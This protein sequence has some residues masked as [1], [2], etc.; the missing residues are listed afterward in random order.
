MACA[1][2]E[3]Q[4]CGGGTEIRG[5]FSNH[6]HDLLPHAIR[7]AGA[8]GRLTLAVCG[9]CGH[10]VRTP[11]RAQT[12][13]LELQQDVFGRRMSGAEI[14][15]LRRRVGWP[16]LRALVARETCRIVEGGG[17]ALDIGCGDGR[18]LATL[19]SD[20]EKY[21]IELSAESAEVARAVSGAEVFNGD[22]GDFAAP[23]ASFNLITAFS[24]ME[25]LTQPEGLLARAHELLEPGGVLV[26]ATPDR[27]SV[28]ARRL[29]E[30]WQIGRAHV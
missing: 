9:N 3:C 15:R 11:I 21:G 25:H 8:G 2:Y 26:L 22:F 20:W 30:Q 6:R 17:R 12:A 24:V 5:P 4:I 23:Q 28:P 14:E 27:E 7:G 19:G 10:A 1:Q 18:W 13:N 16:R 29:S